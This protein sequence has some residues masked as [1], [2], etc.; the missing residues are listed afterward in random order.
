MQEEPL[1]QTIEPSNL[2]SSLLRL[3]CRTAR[4]YGRIEIPNCD[5]G[6]CVVISKDE[7]DCLE[8]ALE[9]L[10][11]THDAQRIRQRV[12]QTLQLDGDEESVPAVEVG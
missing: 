4:E 2:Q 10:A 7:L 8:R 11:A 3:L 6:T 12:Q 1:F 5:G 9:I